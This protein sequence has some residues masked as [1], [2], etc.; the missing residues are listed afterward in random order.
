[1]PTM[2]FG[3]R[4][5]PRPTSP[6]TNLAQGMGNGT[7][8]LQQAGGAVSSAPTSPLMG[9]HPMSQQP[10]LPSMGGGA[11]MA[12]SMQH[13]TSAPTQPSMQSMTMGT[14]PSMQSM[15]SGPSQ[16]SMQP[17]TSGS[18]Q[19]FMGSMS[20]GPQQPTMG[21][22]GMAPQLP[23]MQPLGTDHT[24]PSMQP[25]MGTAQQQP[26]VPPWLM[27]KLASWGM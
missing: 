24:M 2:G 6:L 25:M 12:P 21:S 5:K 3:L 19:P 7:Q 9:L 8:T 4:Q 14:A 11:G 27:A 1:M 22:M 23:S 18:T 16:P 20:S 17:M 26:T 13:M 15:S 10:T